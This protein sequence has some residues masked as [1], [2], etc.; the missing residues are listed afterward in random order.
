MTFAI[1]VSRMI[2]VTR[3]GS[4]RPRI[5]R[6]HI[7]LQLAEYCIFRIVITVL[8]RVLPGL[9][10]GHLEDESHRGAH[11]LASC[12]G[13][14]PTC[15]RI[16]ARASLMPPSRVIRVP[17]RSM[18]A[19]REMWVPPPSGRRGRRRTPR[20]ASGRLP[21]W[22]SRGPCPGRASAWWRRSPGLPSLR[23][24]LPAA[25]HGQFRLLI[26]PNISS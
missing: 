2:I 4:G 16:Q 25:G 1:P 5:K 14:L 7:F 13:S 19:P 12:P 23:G 26:P 20:C 9:L 21:P 24:V 11:W 8:A 18:S 3:V 17:S 10:F 15:L 22:L 6:F